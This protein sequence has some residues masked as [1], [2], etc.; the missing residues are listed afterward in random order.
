MK[1]NKENWKKK[2]PLYILI[3][4]LVATIAYIFIAPVYIIKNIQED[5]KKPKEE[6]VYSTS[7]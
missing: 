5:S 6:R 1:G 2:L 7:P 3:A 4:F